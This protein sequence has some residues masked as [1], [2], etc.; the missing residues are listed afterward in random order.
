MPTLTGSD[1][2]CLAFSS[3]SMCRLTVARAEQAPAVAQALA[4]MSKGERTVVC[5]RNFL[6]VFTRCD[7]DA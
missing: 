6:A 5:S 4:D 7:L 2:F 1:L 3:P